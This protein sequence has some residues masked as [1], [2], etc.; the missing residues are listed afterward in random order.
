MEMASESKLTLG[1]YDLHAYAK[2]PIQWHRAS[3]DHETWALNLTSISF[4]EE[5]LYF[6]F[7]SG[8]LPDT[9]SSVISLPQATYDHFI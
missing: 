9:G 5:P 3:I 6:D 4:G 7:N 8:V 1:D 2:G